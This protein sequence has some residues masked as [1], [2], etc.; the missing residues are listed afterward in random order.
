M[1]RIQI[2]FLGGVLVLALVSAAP[3]PVASQPGEDEDPVIGTWRL[4]VDK[5]IYGDL[6]APRTERRIYTAHP[7]G[8]QTTII[9]VDAGGT[10]QTISYVA[11]YDSVAAPGTSLS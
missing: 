5:S 1:K 11:D 7:A 8:V 10:S 3:L 6:P 4:V 2:S 9:R